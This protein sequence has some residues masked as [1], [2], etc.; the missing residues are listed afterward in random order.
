VPRAAVRFDEGGTK[1]R[2]RLAS[3]ETKD[4]EL[5]ACDAKG[6]AVKSGLAENEAVVVGGAR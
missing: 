6:C 5:D 2:V 3:G 1:T 4:V